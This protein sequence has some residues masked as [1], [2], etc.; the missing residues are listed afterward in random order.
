MLVKSICKKCYDKY[1]YGLW[2]PS[3]DKL[4]DEGKICCPLPNLPN[5]TYTSLMYIS[6]SE[7]PYYCPYYLEHLI[8]E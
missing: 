6:A 2:L 3:T 8:L 7:I 4:W 5:L 1:F